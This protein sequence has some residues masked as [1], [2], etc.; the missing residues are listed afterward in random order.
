MRDEL[1]SNMKLLRH[2]FLV[3]LLILVC[4]PTASTVQAASAPG[5]DGEWGK[6]VAAAKKE[7]KV[8]V[9]LYHRENIETAIRVFEKTFPDIQLVT[10]STPAAETG[11]RLMAERRAGKFLWDVCICGPTTPFTVL[12]PAKALDPIKPLLLL[13]EV[14]DQTKWWEGQHHYMD[15]GGKSYLRFPRQRRYAESLLQ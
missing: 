6:T 4:Q 14:V 10:A 11:P 7:G 1:L 9:F 3:S 8:S 5:A 2:P 12:Y 15:P 13:P